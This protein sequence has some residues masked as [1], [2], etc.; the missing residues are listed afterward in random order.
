MS[1]I[2][3]EQNVLQG[4]KDRMCYVYIHHVM[5]IVM[6]REQKCFRENRT[7]CVMYMMM[8]REQKCFRENR[9]GCVNYIHHVMKILTKME[10]KVVRENRTGCVMY[11]VMKMEQKCSGKTGQDVLTIYTM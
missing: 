11:I 10:Q 3:D 5:Y 6:K 4:K 1:C 8:K 7:G 9:T 2:S